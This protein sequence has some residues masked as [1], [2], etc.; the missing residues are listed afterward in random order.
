MAVLNP[1]FPPYNATGSGVTDGTAALKNCF[2]AAKAGGHSVLST[3]IE[4]PFV[5]E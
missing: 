5:I 2:N 3:T 1:R 4:F